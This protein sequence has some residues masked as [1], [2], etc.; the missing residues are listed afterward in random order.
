ML[1]AARQLPHLSSWQLDGVSKEELKTSYAPE[2]V[3]LQA[4]LSKYSALGVVTRQAIE[5][6]V[7]VALLQPQPH[8]R[9]LDMCA[10]PGSKTTQALEAL[11]PKGDTGT[12]GGGGYMVANDMVPARC[13]MLLRRCAARGEL[14]SQLYLP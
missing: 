10:S 6:M 2:H 7:P 13:Q 12:G 9:M 11:A 3:A 1:A 5:S 14:T 8:H 4:W